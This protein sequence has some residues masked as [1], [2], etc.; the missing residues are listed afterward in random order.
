MIFW[1]LIHCHWNFIHFRKSPCSLNIYFK[2]RNLWFD[3]FAFSF[4]EYLIFIS[5]YALS[6]SRF[7]LQG[8]SIYYVISYLITSD[9][10]KYFS[11]MA[12]SSIKQQF[13]FGL[14]TRASNIGI[15]R[16]GPKGVRLSGGVLT[17]LEFFCC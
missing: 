7:W 13:R 1:V 9:V 3:H 8:F 11:P 10:S 16:D 17:P 2:S 14:H 5:Y 15:N 12:L 4:C 6:L